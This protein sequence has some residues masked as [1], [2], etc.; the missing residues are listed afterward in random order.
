[1]FGHCIEYGSIATANMKYYNNMRV[2]TRVYINVR[3]LVYNFKCNN[4]YKV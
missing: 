1:M 3:L 4:K 2:I